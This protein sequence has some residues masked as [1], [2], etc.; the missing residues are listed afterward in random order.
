MLAYV[1]EG[2]GRLVLKDMPRPSA[3]KD[4]VVIKVNA[5]SICGY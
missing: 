1:Y 2:N 4:S 5:C 3:K